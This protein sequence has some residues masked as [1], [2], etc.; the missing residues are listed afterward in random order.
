MSVGGVEDGVA[1][2]GGV[3]VGGGVGAG[4]GVGGVCVGVLVGCSGFIV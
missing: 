1:G 2:E 4:V 3:P